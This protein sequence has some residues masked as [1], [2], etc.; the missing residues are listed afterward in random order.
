MHWGL[1]LLIAVEVPLGFWMVNLLDASLGAAA[2]NAL[3]DSWVVRTASTHHTIGF[4]ILALALLRINW[5][6]NHPTP[7]LPSGTATHERY[8]ARATQ[9]FLYFLMFFYPLT[10]WAILSTA[11]DGPTI[12]FFTWEIPRLVSTQ[13]AGT[14]FASNLFTT[15]HQ[16]C[17]KV[18]GAL[19]LLH[20]CGALW[21]QFVRRDNL[22]TRMWKGGN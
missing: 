8:L 11:P 10:G 3:V 16:L 5:R 1:V 21:H 18:G 13:S 22:L 6:L 4:L 9:G 17:W 12:H 19:L 15:L 20:V 14:E 7:A 2:G